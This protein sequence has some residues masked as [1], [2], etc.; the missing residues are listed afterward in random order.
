MIRGRRR[1]VHASLSQVGVHALRT[2]LLVVIV[3]TR[4]LLFVGLSGMTLLEV[5]TLLLAAEMTKIAPY[6]VI[7]TLHLRVREG[8]KTSVA[9]VENAV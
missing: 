5:V 1:N 9:H 6:H 8:V 7:V 3:K 4:S 2:N